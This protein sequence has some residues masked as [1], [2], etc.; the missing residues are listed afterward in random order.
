MYKVWT[1][2]DDAAMA[3]Y[4]K[5]TMALTAE[6]AAVGLYSCLIQLTCSLK[7]HGY[8]PRAYKVRR[9]FQAFAL[10]CNLYRY[11]T[12]GGGSRQPQQLAPA[13]GGAALPGAA[14]F[15]GVAPVTSLALALECVLPG[16]LGDF[17]FHRWG[18]YKLNPG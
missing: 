2:D 8:N 6:V 15:V 9:H 5:L 4:N 12:G 14:Y 18:L 3:S 16:N 13:P 10:K 7:A 17:G 1:W 11:T